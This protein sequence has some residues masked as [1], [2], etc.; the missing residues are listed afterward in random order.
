[1]FNFVSLKS[2]ISKSHTLVSIMVAMLNHNT[3]E[4]TIDLIINDL[5]SLVMK[6]KNECHKFKIG[7]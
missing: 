7:S 3:D 5:N 2:Q 4:A 6:I 1:M